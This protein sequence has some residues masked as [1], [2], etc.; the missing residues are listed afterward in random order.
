MD[1]SL[2]NPF[3]NF[4]ELFN[5]DDEDSTETILE[6]LFLVE[7]DHMPSKSYIKTLKGRDLDNSLRSR[8]VSSILQVNLAL[9]LALSLSILLFLWVLIDFIF[10]VLLQ[11]SCKFDPFLSY[12]A[13]SYMDRYLSSQEMPQPK[14]WKLRLLAVSCFSL[15]A[16]MR[17]IEFSYTQFQADGGLIFDTQTIQRMECLILGA[18]K[19]R[20]RSITPF[21]FLSFFISLF[22]LKDLTVQR[23]LKTRASEVIF[24][25]QIGNLIT[26]LRMFS[27][28]I[29]LFTINLFSNIYHLHTSM[30]DEYESEIDLVSSSYTPVN[31]LDCRVSSSESDKTNVTT[32]DTKA[33]SSSSDSSTTSTELSP[34]RDTKRRKLSSYR[35]NHSIQLSQTQQC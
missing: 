34:E 3:T 26:S 16:K 21:T 33:T 8:A 29:S 18:L 7:S 23:A 6:S 10:N 20:M 24:Q 25:A 19:W 5:D 32:T 27:N 12:L 35:N 1:F 9:M 2:E 31:V 13:V 22:K 15:A 11:F 4:H 17:Q 30:D 28:L 14:P